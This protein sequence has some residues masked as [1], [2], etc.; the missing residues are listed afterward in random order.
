MHDKHAK[1]GLVILTVTMDLASRTDKDRAEGR[2]AV[3]KYLA[4]KK[5]PFRTVNLD[6]VDPMKPPASLNFGGEVPGAFVFNRDG[7]YVLKLPLVDDKG[8]SVKEFDYDAVDKAAL[9]ALKK[10]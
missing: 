2:A 6:I 4:D 5:P 3:E 8:D 10:K 1:D 9:E 7:N